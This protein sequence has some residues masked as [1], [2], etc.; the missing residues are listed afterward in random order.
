MNQGWLRHPWDSAKLCSWL[1][2]YYSVH[3][4]LII[5]YEEAGQENINIQGQRDRPEVKVLCLDLGHLAL[6]PQ[7]LRHDY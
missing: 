4:M 1:R 5:D 3:V 6:N 7:H 2:P